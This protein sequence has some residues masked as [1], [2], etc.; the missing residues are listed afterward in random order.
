M[1]LGAIKIVNKATRVRIAGKPQ[2]FGIFCRKVKMAL[3]RRV[4]DS[5]FSRAILSRARVE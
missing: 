1:T 4:Q 5:T 3:R 2:S